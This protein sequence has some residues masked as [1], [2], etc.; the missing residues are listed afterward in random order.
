MANSTVLS[1]IG[2]SWKCQSSWV[3]NVS[4][5]SLIIPIML[6]AKAYN[7]LECNRERSCR[8]LGVSNSVKKKRSR[9]LKRLKTIVVPEDG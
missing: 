3:L 2:S 5:Y 9:K 7:S 1:K 8:C 6:T 4:N